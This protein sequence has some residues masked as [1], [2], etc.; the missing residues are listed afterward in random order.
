LTISF[1]MGSTVGSAASKQ[2]PL[3]KPGRPAGQALIQQVFATGSP[4]TQRVDCGHP[5]TAIG[6]AQIPD[7]DVNVGKDGRFHLVW[8]SLGGWSGTCRALILRFDVA[9]W[10]DASVAFLVGFR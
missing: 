2:H 7:V 9:G 3:T 8:K 1:D 10:R 6:P 4:L 5:A